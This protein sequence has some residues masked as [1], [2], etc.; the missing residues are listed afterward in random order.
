MSSTPYTL[1]TVMIK[2]TSTSVNIFA[3][4]DRNL[5][6]ANTSQSPLTNDKIES[7]QHPN[8]NHLA[9]R[10]ESMKALPD[11]SGSQSSFS[12]NNDDMG[13]KQPLITDDAKKGKKRK[14]TT[15]SNNP[16]DDDTLKVTKTKKVSKVETVPGTSLKIC[17]SCGTVAETTKAKK[18]V[19][20]QKFFYDNDDKGFKG[21]ETSKPKPRR[22]RRRMKLETLPGTSLKICSSCGAVAETPKAKKCQ[23][24]QKF[25][26][27][28]WAQR[29][30]VPPCP[31][32]YFSRRARAKEKPPF[33]CDRCGF[34][35]PSHPIFEGDQSLINFTNASFAIAKLESSD[36]KPP[37]LIPSQS[38]PLSSSGNSIEKQPPPDG[39]NL[40]QQN[41][42][43]G[44]SQCDGIYT[45]DVPVFGSST[46]SSVSVN[47]VLDA[48]PITKL[49]VNSSSKSVSD[50]GSS[51]NSAISAIPHSGLDGDRSAGKQEM[52]ISEVW[53]PG[54]STISLVKTNANTPQNDNQGEKS[55][56]PAFVSVETPATSSRPETETKPLEKPAVM[57][58][59]EERPTAGLV[60]GPVKTATETMSQ[61]PDR[62]A[63]Q[64]VLVT[65]PQVAHSIENVPLFVPTQRDAGNDR[66]SHQNTLRTPTVFS[67]IETKT[68]AT[69]HRA[70]NVNMVC[71]TSPILNVNLASS[72]P[73]PTMLTSASAIS[74]PVDAPLPQFLHKQ[75]QQTNFTMSTPSVAHPQMPT[76]L[77]NLEQHISFSGVPQID[78]ITPQ[79]LASSLSESLLIPTGSKVSSQVQTGSQATLP[80]TTSTPSGT[81]AMTQA[82]NLSLYETM[83]SLFSSASILANTKQLDQLTSLSPSS[84]ALTASTATPAPKLLPIED[85]V[86]T[87]TTSDKFSTS[88]P[89]HIQRKHDFTESAFSGN[90]IKFVDQFHDQSSSFANSWCN[91]VQTFNPL[92]STVGHVSILPALSLSNIAPLTSVVQSPAPQPSLVSNQ[93]SEKTISTAKNLRS[94]GIA[95][96]VTLAIASSPTPKVTFPTIVPSVPTGVSSLGYSGLPSTSA[97]PQQAVSQLLQHSQKLGV[98][99]GKSLPN[100]PSLKKIKELVEMTVKQQHKQ[101]QHQVLLQKQRQLLVDQ[102][103]TQI[104]IQKHI[105]KSRSDGGSSTS[106]KQETSAKKQK[107]SSQT[108]KRQKS[109][110]SE[111]V[112]ILPKKPKKNSPIPKLSRISTPE[113]ELV[114]DL[115]CAPPEKTD[116]E[117][118]SPPLLETKNSSEQPSSAG[119]SIG[120]Q[121]VSSKQAKGNSVGNQPFSNEGSLACNETFPMIDNTSGDTKDTVESSHSSFSVCPPL[122]SSG[123]HDNEGVYSPIARPTLSSFPF[124]PPPLVSSLPNHSEQLFL[125]DSK[126]ERSVL[127]PSICS[128]LQPVTVESKAIVSTQSTLST[129]HSVHT[130]TV[131]PSSFQKI[132]VNTST[133]YQIPGHDKIHVSLLKPG[134]T[135][136]PIS[137]GTVIGL[138]IQSQTIA[139]SSS[140][141]G[142]MKYQNFAL[143]H[144]KLSVIATVETQERSQVAENNQ[145]YTRPPI[146]S[147]PVSQ[148]IKEGSE[149][150]STALTKEDNSMI[151]TD[152]TSEATIPA[153]NVP[154]I[155]FIFEKLASTIQ[156]RI[157]MALSKPSTWSS[158]EKQ[159]TTN[160][161][162]IYQ[163]Q[164]D[165][166]MPLSSTTSPLVTTSESKESGEIQESALN[167][168]DVFD[169]NSFDTLPVEKH[170]LPSLSGDPLLATNLDP[171]THLDSQLQP[172]SDSASQE[173]LATVVNIVSPV[174]SVP[175][176]VSSHHHEPKSINT[177]N[178]STIE[179]IDSSDTASVSRPPFTRQ[180]V[181]PA[182]PGM[183]TVQVCSSLPSN[184][185]S[186]LIKTSSTASIP[187]PPSL[188]K[189]YP[190]ILRPRGTVTATIGNVLVQNLQSLSPSFPPI[191]G[192]SASSSLPESVKSP[193]VVPKR[194]VFVS[195]LDTIEPGASKVSAVARSK[196]SR[197]Q[198][199]P[200]IEE[201]EERKLTQRQDSNTSS[202]C[203]IVCV[204]L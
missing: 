68:V 53:M 42:S 178:T 171:K 101:Q 33:T 81:V 75:M 11:E 156:T 196:R 84:T 201:D 31:K 195:V 37:E 117:Q 204:S 147:D 167:P 182:R 194:G 140:I 183:V 83:N 78:P 185:P 135:C 7:V 51:E 91:P 121:A 144:P 23:K 95:P 158:E 55:E 177:A 104:Q 116:N 43:S 34:E 62:V 126:P 132:E 149:C 80:M 141:G 73:K 118:I 166:V 92:Q 143:S 150:V 97:S 38:E 56:S 4:V 36:S 30:R 44:L 54:E 90:T 123:A 176:L 169:S 57:F 48:R 184:L 172:T 197:L 15:D 67:T 174:C 69:V 45:A 64:N 100:V 157:N 76:V 71:N 77:S 6:D 124:L 198:L 32:C 107:N 180:T 112:P 63:E 22:R 26:Y 151:Q 13:I 9:Q 190:N 115:I 2:P 109:R 108:K 66:V 14:M 29:C 192:L 52:L 152:L 193:K 203:S 10:D 134:S 28:H 105:L 94:Q 159:V 87:G 186:A 70:A 175:K 170:P 164:H 114:T 189:N 59:I 133:V 20:C 8:P 12:H 46:T 202:E 125:S 61:E 129:S 165:E 199:A 131:S 130:S 3:S 16:Q 25:F 58:A 85:K 74:K 162:S 119:V 148:L 110:S 136:T 93:S 153:G 188:P 120:T 21:D 5:L 18:C 142:K 102:L 122:T 1:P 79:V 47:P 41:S 161:T 39:Q 40:P 106:E 160:D 137:P 128:T 88:N 82:G 99:F 50:T 72:S 60:S 113:L 96:S 168:L 49:A 103:Q 146:S 173:D 86:I 139:A 200:L 154:K 98:N 163:C 65:V 127:S 187:S 138:P 191:T 179:S 35:L 181:V 155:P 19:N 24:C 27:D 17:P 111:T 89:C 145:V